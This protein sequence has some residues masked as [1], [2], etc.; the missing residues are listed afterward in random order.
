MFIVL[1]RVVS[2]ILHRNDSFRL[3]IGSKGEAISRLITDSKPSTPYYKLYHNN[4]NNNS[5]T[6]NS[7]T[8]IHRLMT[9]PK[10]TLFSNVQFPR[11]SQEYSDCKVN[12]LL[13]GKI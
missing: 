7:S 6:D 1:V 12:V 13:F 8:L 2:S 5:F 4:F 3:I 9:E 11:T 10:S